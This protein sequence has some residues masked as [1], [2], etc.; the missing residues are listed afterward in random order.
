MSSRACVALWAAFCL[1]PWGQGAIAAVAPP[2][3]S[4]GLRSTAP[5]R[6]TL[7]RTSRQ[8]ASSGDPIWQLRLE[9]PGEHPRSFEA[10]VG[11]AAKQQGDR[12][13]LGSQA[14]LPRGTYHVSEILSLTELKDLNPELGKLFWIGLEPEFATN[15]RGL[16][17]H[18]DPSA[19]K[20]QDSGTDGCIGLIHP[21]ELLSLGELLRRSGTTS[22]LVLN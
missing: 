10:L 2:G 3:A 22:L 14:P 12:H 16:G 13:S 5:G 18:L 8:L 11:R 9:I 21:Q 4:L 19:G 17:I 20:P 15:R 7:L 1:F 6:M